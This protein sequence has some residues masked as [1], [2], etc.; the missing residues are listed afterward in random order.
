MSIIENNMIKNCDKESRI[1]CMSY[2]NLQRYLKEFEENSSTMGDMDLSSLGLYL[3]KC[4]EQEINS[5]VVQ[6]IRYYLGIDMPE[7][8]CRV[9][10]KFSRY[11]AAV[12]TGNDSV[13]H[14]I[15]FNDYRDF[16][17]KNILRPIPLGDAYRAMC[18]VIE[19]D[20][21]WFSNYPVLNNDTFKETWRS[22]SKIRN[23][24][25]HSGT[26]IKREVLTECLQYC[27]TFLRDYMP[28][29]AVIKDELAPDGWLDETH[30]INI[31]SSITEQP[32][33]KLN[34]VDAIL[35]QFHRT[36]KPK[37]T[38]VNYDFWKRLQKNFDEAD[39][40]NFKEVEECYNLMMAYQNQFDWFDIPY[41]DNG[42]FGLKDILGEIVIP[43]KYDDF[44]LLQSIVSFY[45][46]VSAVKKG[47]YYGLVERYTGKELTPFE[48]TDIYK[49]EFH[50]C[51]LFHKE[52]LKSFGIVNEKGKELIPCIADSYN[53][54]TVGILYKSCEKYGYLALDY[55]LSIPPMY[56]DFI[57]DDFNEPFVFVING[58]EG[59]ISNTGKFY[60]KDYLTRMEEDD[61]LE[62]VE[63]WDLL[64][65]IE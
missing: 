38:S 52:G 49:L 9:D 61:S 57:F 29:L 21:D 12:D 50:G 14:W 46:P 62:Y 44:L 5:T 17:H 15:N 20:R 63:K 13:H 31:E 64:M 24:I 28:K 42:K 4:V 55:D 37:A 7:Y 60:T 59:C 23:E 32:K 8:Y 18:V 33:P 34:G 3:C 10:P 36:G 35:A 43:A 16:N 22:I 25:A 30:S 19:E 56:D 51:Y 11:D 53:E 58:V 2:N 54:F 48:Y 45:S 26:I 40:D 1:Y 27:L 65:E 39:R 6:L 47:K 41:E